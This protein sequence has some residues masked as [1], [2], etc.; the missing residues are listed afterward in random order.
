MNDQWRWMREVG[1]TKWQTRHEGTKTLAD[2]D[3]G[4]LRNVVKLL[5]R[6]RARALDRAAASAGDDQSSVMD[7]AFRD[8]DTLYG[9]AQ[10]VHRYVSLREQHNLLLEGPK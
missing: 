1:K 8:A 6:R 2:M 10:T 4:H 9:G 3:C 7:E 5:R